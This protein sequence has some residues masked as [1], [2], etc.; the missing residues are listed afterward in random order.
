MSTTPVIGVT[1]SIGTGKSTFAEFLTSGEGEYFDADEIAK[2][3][4]RPGHEAH[5]QV[6]EEFG[7]SI[8]DED[9]YI[10]PDKLAEV[11]FSDR[12]KLNKLESILHPLVLKKISNDIDRKDSSF[13]VI[14]APLLFESGADELC[15]WIVVVTADEDVVETRLEDRALTVEDIERRRDRQLPESEKIER[16]DEFVENNSSLDKLKSKAR[17]LL[18]RIRNR[19]FSE[20]KNDG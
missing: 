4:M 18:D 6:V 16:A 17:D 7:K 15:D 19:S 9:G 1:G 20:G 8:I 11:V 13:Y 12:E 14:E 3:L 10:Q 5:E 2:N